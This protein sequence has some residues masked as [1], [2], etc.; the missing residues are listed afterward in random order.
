MYSKILIPLDGSK[1]A[2]NVIPYGLAFARA[3]D[4]PVELLQ[5]IEHVAS[6]LLSMVMGQRMDDAQEESPATGPN[7]DAPIDPA[8]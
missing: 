3:F 4:A 2:E 7:T 6:P 1:L 5:V 8:T